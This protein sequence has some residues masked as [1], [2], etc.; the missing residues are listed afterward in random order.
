MARLAAENIKA[1]RESHVRA[2]IKSKRP[3]AEIADD[4]DMTFPEVQAIM[5]A[6]NTPRKGVI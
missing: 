2:A 1:E 3:L 6:M 4:Y 5:V